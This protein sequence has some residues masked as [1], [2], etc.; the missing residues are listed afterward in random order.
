MSFERV[1]A[2]PWTKYNDDVGSKYFLDSVVIEY[3]EL[4]D[5]G[6]S[7]D[8]WFIYYSAV[9][10]SYYTDYQYLWGS[11]FAYESIDELKSAIDTDAKSRGCTLINN[12]DLINLL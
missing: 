9:T 4:L 6:V 10:K 5:E 8:Y 7:Y 3:R 11:F 1:V 12:M 2:L